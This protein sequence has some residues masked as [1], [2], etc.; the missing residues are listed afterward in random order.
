M[1]KKS[2]VSAMFLVA[3]ATVANICLAGTS[4]TNSVEMI[5]SGRYTHVRNIPTVDQKNPLKVVVKT[6][7]PQSVRTVRSAIEFL[8]ARSGFT[9]AD[10]VVLSE[11]AKILMGLPL[12]QIHR[13]LGPITL[14]EALQT[15][16][17]DAYELV[18]D[19]IHRRV[20]FELSSKFYGEQ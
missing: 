8:L 12:P 2:L 14:D 11:E 4:S 10:E 18:V 6:R 5:Q 15:L 16:S 17:G 3:S 1:K 7:I 19:P 13:S 20:T 9:L